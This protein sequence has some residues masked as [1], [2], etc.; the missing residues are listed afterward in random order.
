MKNNLKSR[1][2]LLG[3]E[4]EK[5]KMILKAKSIVSY[6]GHNISANGI[7]NFNVNAQYSQLTNTIQLMQMLNNDIDIKVKVQG[8]ALKLGSFRIKKITIDGDGESKIQLTSSVDFVE[9]DNLN[10]LPLSTDESKEFK[11]LFETDAEI[12]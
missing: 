3:K 11:I 2:N 4:K 9:V 7:V 8:Q 5:V 6:N 10:L 12:E 1:A